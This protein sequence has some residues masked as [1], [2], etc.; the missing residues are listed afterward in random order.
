MSRKQIEDIMTTAAF[1]PDQRIRWSRNL[2]VWVI[3]LGLILSGLFVGVAA[4]SLNY[5]ATLF[6]GMFFGAA[7]LLG[8]CTA[9]Y[10]GVLMPRQSRQLHAAYMKSL[11]RSVASAPTPIVITDTSGTILHANEMFQ[12]VAGQARMRLQDAIPDPAAHVQVRALAEGAVSGT[13][14]SM[15]FAIAQEDGSLRYYRATAY[16]FAANFD[17]AVW[18]LID[19]TNLRKS[20]DEIGNQVTS[21]ASFL[22]HIPLGFLSMRDTGEMVFVNLTFANWVGRTRKELLE[23]KIALQEFVPSQPDNEETLKLIREM[24]EIDAAAMTIQGRDGELRFVEVT[25]TVFTE[26]ATGRKYTRT[27]I[28]DVGQERATQNELRSAKEHFVNFFEKAP[29]GIALVDRDGHVMEG[30]QAAM[31][32]IERDSG[33]G[34]TLL[35][36][37][38]EEDRSDLARVLCNV[39]DARNT[40]MECKLTGLPERFVQLYIS[41]ASGGE[42]ASIIY[43]HET[44]EQ[45]NLELQ[46]AQSQK[47]Q[48]VGQLA[49]GIAHDFNNLLTAILGFS[50]LLLTRHAAGDPSFTDIM[51]VKQNANRAASLVRQLLAFSRQQRLNPTVLSITD[52]LAEVSHLIRRLIGENIDLNISNDRQLGQVKVDQGQLEQVIINLAVNARDAMPDGGTLYVR[53]KNISATE[54]K[55]LGHTLMPAADYVMIEVADTGTGIPKEVLGKIFEPFFTTKEVGQGTG[56]GLS[57]VYGIIKQTGGF[58]FPENRPEGGAAF[59]IYL[60]MYMEQAKEEAP[61]KP[62]EARH[63][64]RDLTGRGTIL[65]VEDEDA[66]RVFASRALQNKGYNVLEARSGEAALEIVN[67]HDGPIH[68]MVSDVVMPQMDGPTLLKHAREKRQDMKIIFISGYAENA[69]AK[70]LERMDFTFLPKPFSLKKLAETVKDVMSEE[71]V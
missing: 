28:R 19:V 34:R 22:D 65:L 63:H 33:S 26:M 54:S 31:E 60:P 6:A 53:T 70:N 39:A 20:V 10:I 50:D 71:M 12:A 57:T 69:F 55:T 25:Q 11:R 56:L 52:V 43:L 29:L 2:D 68:L 14:A 67:T 27:I 45:K 40:V 30:N 24:K 23:H 49:G 41:R 13:A 35:D 8:L 21:L 9:G 37:V 62:P 17:Q 18:F 46:F 58:I 36:A 1:I 4:A 66:V 38:A 7:A 5:G 47:M 15:E 44:T 51:Q 42:S 59:R 48:A 16:P 64:V 3:I 32:L 61:V